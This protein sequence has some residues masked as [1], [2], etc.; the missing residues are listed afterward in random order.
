MN[1]TTWS[2]Q[3][4][5]SMGQPFSCSGKSGDWRGSLELLVGLEL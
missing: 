2:E 1:M 3:R 5:Y 4:M